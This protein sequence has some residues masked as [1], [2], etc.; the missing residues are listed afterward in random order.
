MPEPRSATVTRTVPATIE[1]SDATTAAI[2]IRKGA[3]FQA[4]DDFLL[5][6]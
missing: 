6:P 4:N 1:A 2:H 5:T 3:V